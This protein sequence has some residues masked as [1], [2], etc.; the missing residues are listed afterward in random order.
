MHAAPQQ[1]TI[2]IIADG[3][4]YVHADMQV[5]GESEASGRTALCRCGASRLMPRC[6]NS[7]REIGFC[8]AGQVSLAMPSTELEERALSI[9]ALADG[10]LLIEG[11]FTLLDAKGEAVCKSSKAALCRCGAS[12][13]KPYC[14]GSHDR[15]GFR[16][17]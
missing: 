14:D 11:P 4:L 9:R 6:D 1:N 3:P 10:P 12:K 2:Q 13:M 5:N 8:D 16:A 7:H 17:K 15:V